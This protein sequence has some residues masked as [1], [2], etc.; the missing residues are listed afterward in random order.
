[1][2][3]S[4]VYRSQRRRLIIGNWKMNGTRRSSIQLSEAITDGLSGVEI[5]SETAGVDVVVCPPFVYLAEVSDALA[6]SHLSLGAQ[7]LNE[8]NDGAFTGEVSAAMLLEFACH[9]VL[10]GH[11]ERRQVLGET[12][13][14][15]TDKFRTAAAAGL[16]PVLCV[17]ET[18]EQRDAGETFTVIDEQLNAVVSVVGLD[19]LAAA[20]IAYEP[21]WAIGTGD[22]AS[23]AQAQA[24]HAY[25]RAY[26][27]EAGRGTRLLYGGSVNADNAEGLFS[28]TD[29]D[30]GLVGGASLDAGQFI[31]ICQAAVLNQTA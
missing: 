11:S 31:A 17:G 8:H 10:V 16:T 22:T 14:Q 4:A 6:G 3:R 26:L 12:N 15:T 20:V 9:Y 19:A 25:I 29:I 1:M 13:R 28:E 2:S 24:V 23:P 21:V 30:G 7:T 18:L 5:E 27:G